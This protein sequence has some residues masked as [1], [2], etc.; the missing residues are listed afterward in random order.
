MHTAVEQLEAALATEFDAHPLAP[1][2][3]SAPGL[4]PVLAAR[5]TSAGGLRAFRRH[6]TGHPSIRA[7]PAVILVPSSGVLAAARTL[8]AALCFR[9][10]NACSA[11]G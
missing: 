7:L 4:G 1:V 10:G 2:L 11:C 8:S 3:R 9:F 6:R 5:F